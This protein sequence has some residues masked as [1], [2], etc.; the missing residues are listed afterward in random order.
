MK[1]RVLP[2]TP[3]R[4]SDFTGLFGSNGACGG[5]W[6]MVPRLSRK[7]FRAGKGTGNR[8]A[9]RALVDAGEV[10]GLLAY[11]GKDAVGWIS[12]G[13]RSGF[14]SLQRS[15]V[16]APLDDVPAWFVVCFFV[17]KEWR[18]RGLTVELLK[19]ASKWAFDQGAPRV[20]ACPFEYEEDQPP[21]F[22]WLGLASAYRKAGFEERARRSPK[23][24]Y[25]CLE[26]NP[27]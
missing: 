8:D 17:K 5:C 23:R 7:E 1:L 3:A 20:E 27:R 14:R 9:M 21:P 6:C 19:Q 15:R 10:P 16:A 26:A 12:L 2:L 22:V 4:W 25:M 11:A 13:P 24:P 18:R